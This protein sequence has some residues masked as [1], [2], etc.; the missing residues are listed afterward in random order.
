MFCDMMFC[1]RCFSGPFFEGTT[2]FRNVEKCSPSDTVARVRKSDSSRGKFLLLPR[3]KS[4]F[5]GLPKSPCF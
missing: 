2:I 4:M 1:G 5:L 3:K